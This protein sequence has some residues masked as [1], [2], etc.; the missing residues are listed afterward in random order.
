MIG[1]IDYG[2]GNL[3][4]VE[5]AF[6][7]SGASTRF[8]QDPK[9]FDSLQGL[10]LPGVGAFGDCV[11]NLR[12]SGMWE[13]IKTWVREGRPLFGICLGYQMLFDS[14]EEAPGVEGLGI[15]KGKVIRFKSATLKIPQMGWNQIYRSKA[16]PALEGIEEGAY[17]YFVHSYYPV[18][19]DSSAIALETEYEV[20]FA[21]GIQ[22]GA[23]FGVQFHP[24]KS[25]R[26]GLRM[27]RN[28]VTGLSA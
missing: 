3:R 17:V 5:K 6:Q 15:L 24:E 26:V 22:L 1:I 8:V 14:S 11:K 13:P 7:T 25:Q 20:R 21:S 2:M 19:D 27:I 16:T 10:V 4:S 9:C 18:P 28:F 23:L 12:A